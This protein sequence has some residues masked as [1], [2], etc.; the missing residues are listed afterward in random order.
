MVRPSLSPPPGIGAVRELTRC[1]KTQV[2]ARA[3]DLQRMARSMND[4]PR[5]ALGLM[6][7]S[8]TLTALVALTG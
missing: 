6:S 1:R 5:K 3:K 7:P 2:D 8:E 4:R